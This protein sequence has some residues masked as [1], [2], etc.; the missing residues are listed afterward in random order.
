MPISLMRRIAAV[1]LAAGSAVA[2]A[3]ACSPEVLEFDPDAGTSGDSPPPPEFCS[4]VECAKGQ[5]CC[6][7]NGTCF[8]ASDTGACPLADGG[9]RGGD[10]NAEHPPDTSPCASNLDCAPG[11]FCTGHPCIGPGICEVPAGNNC[12]ES[13]GIEP[14]CGCDGKTY[15][16][17][18]DTCPAR[19]R[20]AGFAACGHQRPGEAPD[21][22]VCALDSQ[23]PDGFQCCG[24]TGTCFDP[25]KPANCATVPVAYN[26]ACTDDS[27]C[28]GSWCVE[29]SCG[30]QKAC[31]VGP[32]PKCTSLDAPVCGCDGKTY[33]NG[34]CALHHHVQ[35][36]HDF[37]CK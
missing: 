30:G 32:T 24:V 21:R 17:V 22:V 16:Q 13:S 26:Y 27:D 2:V 29:I 3:T 35:V 6:F 19:V 33:L 37:K 7:A 15:P 8:D 20:V 5:L 31:F 10:G 18:Q 4:G 28:A 11:W 14:V 12:G 36:A 23:C 9:T 1:L 34:D 25:S